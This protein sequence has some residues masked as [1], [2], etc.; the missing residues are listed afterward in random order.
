MK[1]TKSQVQEEARIAIEANGGRGTFLGATGVGKSK[2]PIDYIKK[3]LNAWSNILLVV[4]TEKLRDVNWK[5][6]FEKWDAAQYYENIERSCYIS[7]SKIKGKK[8][9]LVILDEVHNITENNSEFFANNEVKDIIALTATAPD[10]FIK[11]QILTSLRL[12]P[13]YIVTVDEAVNWGLISPYRVVVN[14]VRLDTVH[15]NVKA[16]TKAKPFMTT[17]YNAYKYLTNSIEALMYKDI[18]SPYEEKR[19][20]MLIFK[21][22]RFIYDLE[23]KS[24]A[25]EFLLNQ[26]IPE[27]ERTLIF[28]GSIKQAERLNPYSFHSKSKDDSAYVKF[29]E[30]EI[31]RL[32]GVSSLNEGHN[33]PDVDNALIAQLNS[34][35]LHFIQRVGRTVRYREGHVANIHI[36]TAKDTVDETW[37]E[38]AI[39]G[40]DKENIQRVNFEELK[41]K[42]V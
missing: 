26:I 8:Y 19:L 17:E 25:A 40:I 21:R 38:K 15:K 41:M 4:P 3:H 13:V 23:T 39:G 36:I 33:L 35:E 22:M 27:D 10:S 16:G 28:A 29:V 7:I 34:K 14:Y 24:K 37:T 11:R 6:E 42:Y 2:V 32:S 12:N 1:K 5:N 30:K 9:D 20:Q 18:K 31:N